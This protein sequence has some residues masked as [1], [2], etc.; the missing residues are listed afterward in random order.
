M[1]RAHPHAMIPTRRVE[2][3]AKNRAPH[4]RVELVEKVILAYNDAIATQ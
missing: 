1:S 3:A 2:R 4:A